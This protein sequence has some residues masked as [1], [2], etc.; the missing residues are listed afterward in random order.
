MGRFGIGSKDEIQ[1]R[2]IPG[3]LLLGIFLFFGVTLTD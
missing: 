3:N 1:V 2:K